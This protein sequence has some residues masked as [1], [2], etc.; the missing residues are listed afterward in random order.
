MQNAKQLRLFWESFEFRVT[1]IITSPSLSSQ[2][3][4]DEGERIIQ[5]IQKAY[6]IRFDSLL[7]GA[8]CAA[9]DD[10]RLTFEEKQWLMDVMGWKNVR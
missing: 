10:A 2:Y 9:I 5:A 7:Y 8:F 1:D 6:P 3:V 4:Q